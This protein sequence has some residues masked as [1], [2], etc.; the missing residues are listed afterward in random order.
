MPSCV[1]KKIAL[2]PLYLKNNTIKSKSGAVNMQLGNFNRY[3]YAGVQH[4]GVKI[5]APL[6]ITN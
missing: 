2:P 4:P 5:G 6:A 1:N 3:F